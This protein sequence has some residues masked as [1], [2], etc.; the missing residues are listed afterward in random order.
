MKP[1]SNQSSDSVPTVSVLRVEKLSKVFGDSLVLNDISFTLRKNEILGIIGPS[2][3]G[4]TTLLKCLNLLEDFSSGSV[5][6][7]DGCK[8]YVG[9]DGF[10]VSKNSGAEIGLSEEF[11]S[12]TRRNIGLVFQ[13]FNL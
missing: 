11:R 8:V 6:F 4:K 5:E 3:G 13:N 1:S 12:R 9:D 7:E 10:L 2:G